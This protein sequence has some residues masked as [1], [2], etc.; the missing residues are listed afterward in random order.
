MTKLSNYL[1]YY[2]VPGS[3]WTNFINNSRGIEMYVYDRSVPQNQTV[4]TGGLY[5]KENEFNY[6]IVNTA[7]GGAKQDTEKKN[8]EVEEV[9]SRIHALNC[10]STTMTVEMAVIQY[11]NLRPKG[12]TEI[13]TWKVNGDANE[14]TLYERLVYFANYKNV[15]MSGVRYTTNNRSSKNGIAVLTMG[16]LALLTIGGYSLLRKKKLM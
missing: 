15:P 5:L 13:Q 8:Y 2:D 1:F 6:F 14:V 9:V 4:F 3:A 12:K 10:S 7:D 16:S 11:N